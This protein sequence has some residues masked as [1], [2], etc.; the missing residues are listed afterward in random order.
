MEV[1]YKRSV[2]LDVDNKYV[3]AFRIIPA[4]GGGWQKERLQFSTMTKEL[5]EL[6][7]CLRAGKVT[8]EAMECTCMY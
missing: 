6:A 1:G 5:L 4:A 2:G 8:A 7:D 3:T